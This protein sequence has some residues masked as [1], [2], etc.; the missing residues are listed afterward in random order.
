MA[1]LELSKVRGS[2]KKKK[3]VLCAN[4]YRSTRLAKRVEEPAPSFSK[5]FFSEE[6]RCTL[7][8]YNFKKQ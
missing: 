5:P 8:Y 3:V 4:L 1:C 2:I 7:F 6:K